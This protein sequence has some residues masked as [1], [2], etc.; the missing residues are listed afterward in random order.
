MYTLVIH[1]NGNISNRESFCFLVWMGEKCHL[2]SKCR[3]STK[4][5]ECAIKMR[6]PQQ[7]RGCA[8]ERV[9]PSQGEWILWKKE[10]AKKLGPSAN[11]KGGI[12]NKN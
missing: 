2:Y 6:F 5:G 8:Q 11:K 9:W 4:L 10:S 1:V 7:N 3:F 12:A